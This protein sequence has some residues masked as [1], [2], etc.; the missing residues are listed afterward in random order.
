[1]AQ[2]RGPQVEM[3]VDTSH[4]TSEEKQVLNKLFEV[5]HLMTD[6]FLEQVRP[7]G[8]YP[9][10]MTRQ[11]FE[12][13]IQNNPEDRAN[14][15]SLYTVIQRRGDRLV[16]IPYS[17]IYLET[18]QS[19]AFLLREAADITSNPS[20]KTYLRLLTRAFLTDEYFEAEMA[21]MDLKDTPIEVSIGP[22]E[23]YAD[24]LFGYK[25]YFHSFITIEDPQLSQELVYLKKYLSDM[26]ANLPV[27]KEYKNFRRGTESPVKVVYQLQA[28]GGNLLGLQ[29]IAFNLPNDERIREAKGAK[30]V[31]LKNVLE[32]KFRLTLSKIAQFAIHPR[33]R[34]LVSEKMYFYR[35]LFHEL[36]HSLGPGRLMKQGRLTTVQ[37]EL[38][39]LFLPLEE[40]KADV[41]S[42]Y[43]LLYMLNQGQL[44]EFSRE[45]ILNSYFLGLIYT[46]RFGTI[47]AHGRGGAYQYHFLKQYQAFHTDEQGYFLINF[48]KLEK[49]ITDLV[50]TVIMLQGD[51]D[52][53]AVQQFLNTYGVAP[54]EDVQR[55][56]D[57]ANNLSRGV[58]LKYPDFLD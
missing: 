40:G 12:R 19:A 11:E 18:L 4:L 2:Y 10:D 21:W 56:L 46:M 38:K 30:K 7:N 15:T 42:V 5:S 58:R 34:S 49:G 17:E 20:L 23:T 14:F 25:A 41:L 37:Q 57:R 45:Q 52:Y 13:W 55:V 28:G 6:L 43:N 31:I 26:E 47:H 1:M 8:F 33:L 35:V 22:Y 32:T 3:M 9:V 53:A 24:R 39:E 27:P 54:D 48:D 50:K 16:A 36:S 44:P 51:G 29:A